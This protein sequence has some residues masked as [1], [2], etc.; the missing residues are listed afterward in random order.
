MAVNQQKRRPIQMDLWRCQSNILLV[1]PLL[2]V[3]SSLDFDKYW[4]NRLQA[5]C[6]LARYQHCYIDEI[7]KN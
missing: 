7:G 5:V 3:V 1:P 4:V 2:R 6:T